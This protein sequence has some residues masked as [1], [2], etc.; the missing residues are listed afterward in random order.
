MEEENLFN[1]VEH[2]ENG[3]ATIDDATVT[4][5]VQEAV[6]ENNSESDVFD[7]NKL[8][9][10]GNI[11][12]DRVELDGQTVTIKSAEIKMP[13]DKARLTLSRSGKVEY[14][15]YQFIVYFDT[16]NNDREFLSGCLAFV[17]D[18]KL[19]LPS[20]DTKKNKTQVS[21]LFNVYKQFTMEKNKIPEEEFDQKYGLKAFMAFLNSKPKCVMKTEDVEYDDKVTRKNFVAKFI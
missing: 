21:K 13:H 6:K 11:K 3:K 8:K 14:K 18:G 10:G 17:N 16:E 20:V 1:E 4:Q 7:L 2:K 19:S 12:Y 5:D 15:Q 9:D